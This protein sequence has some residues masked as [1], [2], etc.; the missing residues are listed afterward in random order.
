MIVSWQE[1]LDAT[2]GVLPINKYASG[3]VHYED[4]RLAGDVIWRYTWTNF[5]MKDNPDYVEV[6]RLEVE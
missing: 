1:K 3:G 2:V 5:T 6:Y 4:Y